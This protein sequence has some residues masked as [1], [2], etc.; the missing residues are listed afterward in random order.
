MPPILPAIITL[1]K[2]NFLIGV[3][4]KPAFDRL[5][6]AKDAINGLFRKYTTAYEP[7]RRKALLCLFAF[8]LLANLTVVAAG[9]RLETTV[10]VCGAVSLIA[11]GCA[12]YLASQAHSSPDHSSGSRLHRGSLF[13]LQ[14]RKR[15]TTSG[16]R[17]AAR[18]LD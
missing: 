9:W 15:S 13:E 12:L 8:L 1:F 5:Q 2:G 18:D 16:K 11:I 10:F 7:F 4:F 17:L 3:L 6:A 14:R